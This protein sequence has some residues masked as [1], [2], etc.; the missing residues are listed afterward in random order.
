MP[1]VAPTV[2]SPRSGPGRAARRAGRAARRAS[3]RPARAPSPAAPRSRAGG[4]RASARAWSS[5]DARIAFGEE[6][7]DRP[8]GVAALHEARDEEHHRQ[9]MMPI[10]RTYAPIQAFVDELVRCGMRH[11]VTSPGSRNAPLALTL[12]AQPGLEA[13]SVIDERSRRLLRARHGQGERPAGGRDL[14]LRHRRGQPPPRRGRGLGGARAADRADRRPPARAARGRRRAG[15][16]PAQAL[17]ERR[18]VVRRGRHPRA[19][20]AR[21]RSTTAR[22]PAAPTGPRPAGGRG[23]CT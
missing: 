1:A 23:P 17:R 5:S 16:R 18:Q 13:V 9:R 6:L 10:N 3:S 8:P 12:A 7:R 19:R 15:D 11:A 20:A 14:H 4:P 2:T 22:S 21:P